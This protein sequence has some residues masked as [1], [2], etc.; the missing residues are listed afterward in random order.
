V[1][2]KEAADRRVPVA[3]KT[4]RDEHGQV[5]RMSGGVTSLRCLLLLV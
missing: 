1:A 4:T 5:G 2:G 3:R